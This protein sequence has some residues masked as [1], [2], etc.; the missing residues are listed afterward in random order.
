MIFSSS[1]KNF[2]AAFTSRFGNNPYVP[3]SMATILKAFRFALEPTLRFR[4][5]PWRLMLWMKRSMPRGSMPIA[6]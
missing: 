4:L 5:L 2:T 3:Q 1:A 6:N